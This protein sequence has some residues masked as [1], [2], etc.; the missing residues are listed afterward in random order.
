M[1]T[2][3]S[4]QGGQSP[5]RQSKLVFYPKGHKWIASLA[6]AMTLFWVMPAQAE[7][8]LLDIQEVTSESGISAWLVEDHSIPVIA[9]KFGWRGAGSARD[10]EDKQG[11]ARMLSNTMD[12]GAGSLN[13]QAFQKELRDLVIS[14]SFSASRDDFTGSLK[15]LTKNKDRAFEL[16]EMALTKPRFD[17]E[18]VER[19]RQANQSRIRSSLSDPGWMAARLLN[20]KAFEG[21]PYALNSGGTL[22]SLERIESADL[23][24]LHKSVLGRNNLSVAVAGDITAEELAGVLDQVFSDLPDILLD[25]LANLEIQNAGKTFLYK[26]DIPQSVVEI[27]QPGIGRDDP[28]F[29]SAQVMNFVL[30]SSGFGSRLTEEIREKR[31]LTYGIYSYFYD[32]QHLKGLAVSTSTANENVP[33]MLK[34]IKDEFNKMV[35]SPIGEKEL[36]DAKSY[37]IGSL[38]L[39]LTSTDKIAGLMNSLQLDGRPVDYLDQREK[40]IEETSIEDI[41]TLATELLDPE[42]FI[43][44]IV[45]EPEKLKDVIEVKSLP[46]VE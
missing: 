40:A 46:N 36:R 5:T 4:L 1:I 13:S 15:T 45:G 10:P 30:G 39:S 18:A 43:T 35:S 33:E 2:R 26:R 8:G 6:L 38:P 28:R 9:V 29:H 21:H 23:K 25:D 14:L 22:S 3:L 12:E 34:L 16:L 20:D 24:K 11:L 31:G 27:L 19:M 42:Q 17:K 41:Q 7:D 44:I 32:L 37:L